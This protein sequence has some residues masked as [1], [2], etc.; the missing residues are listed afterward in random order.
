MQEQ[1]F[2]KKE[3]VSVI[4]TYNDLPNKTI[5]DDSIL[6]ISEID[7]HNLVFSFREHEI[8]ILEMV[9]LPQPSPVT[10]K[11]VYLQLKKFNYCERT[12]RRK[13]DKLV[14]LGLIVKLRSVIGIIQPVMVMSGNIRNLIELYYRRKK[15]VN[16]KS[17]ENYQNLCDLLVNKHDEE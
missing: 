3:K 9:Y 11:K 5:I 2:E 4:D 6:K 10:F 14:N 7:W 1:V 13:I 12:S 17:V 8:K 15:D 16:F